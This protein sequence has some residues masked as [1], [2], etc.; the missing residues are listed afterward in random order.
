MSK[1]AGRSICVGFWWGVG[2]IGGLGVGGLGEGRGHRFSWGQGSVSLIYR[3]FWVGCCGWSDARPNYLGPSAGQ[4]V[5][6]RVSN[7]FRFGRVF[8]TFLSGN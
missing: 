4:V 3:T 2:D 8:F 5:S 1:S 7:R 6:G